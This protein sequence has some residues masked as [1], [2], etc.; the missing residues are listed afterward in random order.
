MT[1]NI[2]DPSIQTRKTTSGRSFHQMYIFTLIIDSKSISTDDIIEDPVDI[3]D[4][5]FQPTPGRADLKKIRAFVKARDLEII[6]DICE[7]E[8]TEL[9]EIKTSLENVKLSMPLRERELRRWLI[10]DGISVI[11]SIYVEH[12]RLEMKSSAL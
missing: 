1:I 5:T 7:T 6:F 3:T 8:V 10:G 2:S 12:E 9:E 4:H 11:L